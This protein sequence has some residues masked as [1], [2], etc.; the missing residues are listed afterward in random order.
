MKRFVIEYD[1]NG[2]LF[3]FVVHAESFEAAQAHVKSIIET[4]RATE[5][6]LIDIIPATLEVPAGAVIH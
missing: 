5:W 3:S 2:G 1:H 4:A 6:T